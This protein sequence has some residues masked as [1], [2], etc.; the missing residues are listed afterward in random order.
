MPNCWCSM[1][2]PEEMFRKP[3][4]A[5]CPTRDAPKKKLMLTWRTWWGST[6]DRWTSVDCKT[7]LCLFRLWTTFSIFFEPP[8]ILIVT[9][10]DIAFN[11]RVKVSFC[12]MPSLL[13]L[14]PCNQS[15]YQLFSCIDLCRCFSSSPLI[16]CFRWLSSLFLY[17]YFNNLNGCYHFM[18]GNV[19]LE[20]L[21]A[22]F[23]QTLQNDVLIVLHENVVANCWLSQHLY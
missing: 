6:G 5:T 2:W 16:I 23:W 22:H 3:S 9:E 19:I 20:E 10:M 8:I 17:L 4:N 18:F 11:M 12:W 14:Y 15:F 21:L 1:S 13:N 7:R